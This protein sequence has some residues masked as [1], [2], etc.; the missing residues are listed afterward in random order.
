MRH[1]FYILPAMFLL[2]HASIYAQCYSRKGIMNEACRSL[3]I[4]S[5]P[6]FDVSVG[7]SNTR[8]VKVDVNYVTRDEIV[9]GGSVGA[10]LYKPKVPFVN[11][12][13]ATINGFL[14]YNVVGCII[15]GVT[16]GISHYTNDY[17]MNDKPV[18]SSGYK[19]FVGMSIKLISNFT[20]VPITFGCYGS[21]SGIGITIGTIF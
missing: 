18:Y 3:T 8:I 13:D 12:E 19:K 11:Q 7:M 6:A 21:Q 1:R 15:V 2:I 5:P 14:G 17:V 20:P 9:Y 10:R 4:V 16:A